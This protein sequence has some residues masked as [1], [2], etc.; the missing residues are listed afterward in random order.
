MFVK[1]HGKG[2]SKI[3]CKLTRQIDVSCQQIPST[4]EK[5]KTSKNIDYFTG[6]YRQ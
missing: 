5:Y 4:A 3:K 2:Y 6:N 1:W